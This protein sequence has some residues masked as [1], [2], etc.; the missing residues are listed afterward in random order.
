MISPRT[1]QRL[2][3]RHCASLDVKT[4]ATEDALGY[5]LAEDIRSPHPLPHFDNS[6]MDGFALCSKDTKRASARRPVRLSI[7]ESIFAGDTSRR[8]LRRGEACRIMTGAPLPRGADTVIA[9]EDAIV[10]GPDL[11]IKRPSERYWHVR[12]R[13]EEVKRGA[14]IIRRSAVIHPGTIGCLAALGKDRVRVVRKPRVSVI[15]TGDEAVPPGQ[16]L[17][18]GQIFDSN[19]PM[20]EAMLGEMGVE[21]IRARRVKDHPTALANAVG[22]ALRHSDVLIVVGGVSVGDRDYVRTVFDRLRIRSVFWRVRQKPGKPLFF[23]VK[24]RKLIFGLPGNPASAFTCFYIYVYGALRRLSGFRRA[25]LP[26]RIAHVKGAVSPDAE[27]WLLL[28]GNSRSRSGTDVDRLPKQGSHMITSLHRTNRFIVV[29]PGEA[30]IDNEGGVM[31][32]RLPYWEDSYD[33]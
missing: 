7:G 13:G 24:G 14:T 18:V 26:G 1:A 6:G 12:K 32:Y 5:V 20:L 33:D 30:G 21:S 8:S 28:K 15:T 27:R 22:A 23:G 3:R 17:K 2:I 4:V 31:T 29:E 10:E 19:T 9:K 25:G 16:D 11:V